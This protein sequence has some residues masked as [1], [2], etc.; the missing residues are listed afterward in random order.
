MKYSVKNIQEA[1]KIGEGI[2]L[3]K[4]VANIL[5]ISYYSV[6]YSLKTFWQGYT[7]GQERNKT[8]NFY[9]LIE[10]YT[11]HHLRTQGF[12]PKQIE[13]AHSYLAKELKTNYPFAS[14]KLSTPKEDEKTRKIWYEYAGFLMKLDGKKQPVIKPFIE[15]FLSKIHF[16]ANN[17]AEKYYPVSKANSVVIDPKHQFGEATIEG[18]NIT[19]EFIYKLYRGGEKKKN[20]CIL[21]ELTGKQVG[22]AISYQKQIA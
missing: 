13:K 22:D 15:P 17:I 21:Y 1:P 16:G 9:G 8:I 2:F 12:S 11:Y 5:D 4:D 3:M 10:F 20:I 18:T 19:T 6:R 14:V 7:I